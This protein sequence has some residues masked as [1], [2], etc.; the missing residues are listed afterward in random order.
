MTAEQRRDFWIN[1]AIPAFNNANIFLPLT[2]NDFRTGDPHYLGLKF[3][4][5]FYRDLRV[6]KVKYELGLN[7]GNDNAYV[8]IIF[9]SNEIDNFAL[10]ERF[11]TLGQ[12]YI[13]MNGLPGNLEKEERSGDNTSCRLK[14]GVEVRIR[15]NREAY[16]EVCNSLIDCAF[17]VLLMCKAIN[18]QLE[19]N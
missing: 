18:Y 2:D 6:T 14:Y 11:L 4:D 19:E 5:A 16:D 1:Y 13:Q 10:R 9:N 8:D 17:D 3:N 15:P 7:I 12:R